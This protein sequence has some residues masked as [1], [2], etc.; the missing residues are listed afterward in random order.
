M[1]SSSASEQQKEEDLRTTVSQLRAELDE[2]R[3]TCRLLRREKALEVQRIHDEEQTKTSV[4]MKDLTA[5]LLQE[6]QQ[7]VELQK[8]QLKGKL[9]ADNKKVVKLKDQEIKK[10]KQ[11]LIRCQDE[12]KEEVTKR[13]LSTS[14]R[15][16]FELERNKLLQEVKELNASKKQLESA[17]QLSVDSVK[18]KNMEIR[19]LQDSCKLELAKVEKEA[20]IEVKKLLEELK[21]KDNLLAM[22]DRNQYPDKLS[23]LKNRVESLSVE[24]LMMMSREVERMSKCEE[25]SKPA[26]SCVVQGGCALQ[27]IA[28]Q[29]KLYDLEKQMKFANALHRSMAEK[30]NNLSAINKNL[31]QK[32]K[33]STEQINALNCELQ[34]SKAEIERLN[35]V[36]VSTETTSY[37]SATSELIELQQ[38]NADLQ[39]TVGSLRH[40]CQEKDRRIALLFKS[41]KKQKHKYEPKMVRFFLPEDKEEMETYSTENSKSSSNETDFE[42]EEHNSD[43]ILIQSI[44]KDYETLMEE[45]LKLE[46][47]C[48][49]LMLSQSNKPSLNTKSDSI[50]KE[51]FDVA[52][53]ALEVKLQIADERERMLESHLREVCDQNEELE[54]RILE[55][56]ECAEKKMST[57]YPEEDVELM[58]KNKLLET[59]VIL[60]RQRLA[61][62]EALDVDALEKDAEDACSDRLPVTELLENSDGQHQRL[63][64]E[65]LRK[66][67]SSLSDSDDENPMV[68]SFSTM[69]SGFD[70]VSCISLELDKLDV[71]ELSE[72]TK[73]ECCDNQQSEPHVSD[74]TGTDASL[75]VGTSDVQIRKDITDESTD[76]LLDDDTIPQTISLDSPHKSEKI[77]DQIQCNTFTDK[78][79]S[80]ISIDSYCTSQRLKDLQDQLQILEQNDH[81]YL[82]TI[83]ALSD[84]EKQLQI[85]E[86]ADSNVEECKT[87]PESTFPKVV[88]DDSF[89]SSKTEQLRSSLSIV[90]TH[91]T[92]FISGHNDRTFAFEKETQTALENCASRINHTTH[93]INKQMIHCNQLHQQSK[94]LKQCEQIQSEEFEARFLL[95]SNSTKTCFEPYSHI[96][97]SHSYHCNTPSGVKSLKLSALEAV[98]NSFKRDFEELKSLTDTFLNTV[99]GDAIVQQA[100]TELVTLESDQEENIPV[101]RAKR[102]L[103]LNTDLPYADERFDFLSPTSFESEWANGGHLETINHCLIQ[104]IQDLVQERD[105]LQE[106]VYKDDNIISDMTQQICQLDQSQKTLKKLVGDLEASDQETKLR[107][108][109]LESNCCEMKQKLKRKESTEASLK[110]KLSAYE[111]GDSELNAKIQNYTDLLQSNAAKF[112]DTVANLDSEKQALENRVEEL[113]NL[114]KRLET[115]ETNLKQRVK[116]L[117][118]SDTALENKLKDSEAALG[119]AYDETSRIQRQKD[120]MSQ[121]VN[122]LEDEISELKNENSEVKESIAVLTA[123]N[124]RLSE[125]E[126]FLKESN[127]KMW[128]SLQVTL[129]ERESVQKKN[130]TA[131]KT[132]QLLQIHRIEDEDRFD[133]HRVSQ[134]DNNGRRGSDQS[135][136][137]SASWPTICYKKQPV[138]VIERA[139]LGFRKALL[140][141]KAHYPRVYTA[142]IATA[143]ASALGVQSDD[144]M[145]K[146]VSTMQFKCST[147]P[148]SNAPPTSHV[149]ESQVSRDARDGSH[150]VT[151]DSY[152]S[153]SNQNTS[154]FTG[155][156]FDWDSVKGE[157]KFWATVEDLNDVYDVRAAD[158]SELWKKLEQLIGV[159]TDNLSMSIEFRDADSATQPQPG[160]RASKPVSKASDP[161]PL[162]ASPPPGSD[163]SD[164]WTTA[165]HSILDQTTQTEMIPHEDSTSTDQAY[166]LRMQLEQKDKNLIAKMHEVDR[167]TQ[168]MRRWQQKAV[169]A[170]EEAAKYSAVLG[171]AKEEASS[172][173]ESSKQHARLEPY[174]SQIPISVRQAVDHYRSIDQ[175]SSQGQSARPLGGTMSPGQQGPVHTSGSTLSKSPSR[176]PSLIPKP[177]GERSPTSPVKLRDGSY[178]HTD[179]TVGRSGD[180]SSGLQ[181]SAAAAAAPV[182]AAEAEASAA[183]KS[184]AYM[185]RQQ[186]SDGEGGSA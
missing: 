111:K 31:E 117:E 152:L 100:D 165:S 134:A 45:H 164:V 144:E 68:Q 153:T 166:M 136:Q 17:L 149:T 150:L 145:Q 64:V 50:E 40:D 99:H 16:T 142:F 176:F 84:I 114:V 3:K 106:L 77:A 73:E 13:G 107:V 116:T 9:D 139:S 66:L 171:V 180:I 42:K 123:E 132:S 128:L 95:L 186:P 34:C 55:L 120:C 89:W 113:T 35:E 148:H 41:Q 43:E 108:S 75:R 58:E 94:Y 138:V 24:E 60:L 7:E 80:Q 160:A 85:S 57:Y 102:N 72:L 82:A 83:E 133:S 2:E 71:P 110:T 32:I 96:Q 74:S 161:P 87:K 63:S 119:V 179:A 52:L 130:W 36:V 121:R 112:K 27:T 10:L 51:S 185:T 23:M 88:S 177:I 8:E 37:D 146:F 122:Q 151:D 28:M 49:S 127:R 46:K 53:A 98:T 169:E 167:L 115:K 21:T 163:S 25:M 129:D 29:K 91:L 54:F 4:Q 44:H 183:D 11:D 157:E 105:M 39:Q 47:Y 135:V 97:S 90:K 78:Q 184:A 158:R 143:A 174:V 5:R 22:M 14:A 15:G 79:I 178:F 33:N 1:K 18:H 81:T 76:I 92:D 48:A 173:K 124:E 104:Q 56:E 61:R 59:Q 86:V 12:L 67:T 140:L 162:P 19:Q 159:N 155:D 109:Q 175:R 6:R 137:K 172:G 126:A 62:Y 141:L 65:N 182:V 118:A 147:D 170:S 168:E 70:E 103:V 156:I 30:N 181:A 101:L 69:T 125:S 38:H 26:D 131:E 20:N 93:D 154:S